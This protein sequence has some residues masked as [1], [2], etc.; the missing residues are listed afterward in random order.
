MIIVAPSR[1]FAWLGD[2]AP[3]WVRRF[4]AGPTTFVRISP[5]GAVVVGP[6]WPGRPVSVELDSELVLTTRLTLP[7]EARPDVRE[8]AILKIEAET[9]FREEEILATVTAEGG[10]GSDAE[11]RYR[12]DLTPRRPI[13]DGL[14]ELRLRPDAV[15]L[16]KSAAIG[17]RGEVRFPARSRRVQIVILL[18]T[19]I[20]IGV[21]ISGLFTVA[22]SEADRQHRVA[23]G[24]EAEAA[25]EM[26]S[27]KSEQSA[28]EASE[29]SNSGR[30]ALET[31]LSETP[32]AFLLL[33]EL[34]RGVPAGLDIEKI[35]I[36]D[37]I[38]TLSVRAIDA[39]AA[40]RQMNARPGW[41][42]AAI[43]SIAAD[44]AT[45]REVAIVGVRLS[46]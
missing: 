25:R 18:I 22:F 46:R 42:A 19:A 7:Q 45:A 12:I 5:G 40:I 34:K 20:P 8:A 9:P 43:G 32:S 44:P 3:A 27:L 4:V 17:T 16:I 1:L 21:A 31:L 30:Q 28:L 24:L 37:G 38:V 23:A 11:W 26:I 35:E 33:N 2:I 6:R 41:E 13:E 10:A 15:R 36:A 14:R 39:L 29:A